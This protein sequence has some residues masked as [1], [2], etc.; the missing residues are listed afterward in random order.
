MWANLTQETYH[1]VHWSRRQASHLLFSG[2]G[3]SSYIPSFTGAMEWK[4]CHHGHVHPASL[5]ADAA[6]VQCG[7]QL[8]HSFSGVGFVGLSSHGGTEFAI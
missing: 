5:G 3:I 1:W 4:A 7:K 2:A 6:V 8:S